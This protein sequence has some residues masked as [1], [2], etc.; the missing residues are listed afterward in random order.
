MR[1]RTIL[2]MTPAL[3]LL[4]CLSVSPAMGQS[5]PMPPPAPEGGDTEPSPP[6]LPPAPT[7]PTAAAPTAA[8]PS[9]SAAP[10]NPEKPV[11]RVESG[12][13]GFA[14]RFGGLATMA[15]TGN[16]QTAGQVTISQIAV[17]YVPSESLRVYFAVGTG[18][19]VRA[20][21]GG[22]ANADWGM[23]LGGGFEYHFRIWRRI[24]PFLGAGLFIGMNDPAGGD[25]WNFGLQLGPQIGVEYF[26]GDRVSVQALYNLALMFNFAGNPAQQF[27]FTF[28]TGSGGLLGLTT[29]F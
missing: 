26:I 28:A 11:E 18:I 17:K 8:T 15:A 20:P 25:N 5:D 2:L 14:W 22:D 21:D 27:A 23:N 3:A 1:L 16:A 4:L 7:T 6:G 12:L 9:A 10:S 13:W 29:Y 24:S 19:Q